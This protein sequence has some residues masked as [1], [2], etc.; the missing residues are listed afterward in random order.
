MPNVSI[1]RDNQ[2]IIIDYGGEVLVFSIASMTYDS[3][4]CVSLTV[5]DN[6]MDYEKLR[7]FF[8]ECCDKLIVISGPVINYKKNIRIVMIDFSLMLYGGF[9]RSMNFDNGHMLEIELNFDHTEYNF[10][11]SDFSNYRVYLR[12][13]KIQ[14]LRSRMKKESIV[15]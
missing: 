10:D 13:C 14:R 8:D 15:N 5:Y 1:K 6:S 9:I 3:N 7:K 4:N 2:T 11:T 12:S